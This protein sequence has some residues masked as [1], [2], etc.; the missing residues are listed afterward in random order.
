MH[1]CTLFIR[2]IAALPQLY[3]CTTSAYLIQ[4]HLHYVIITETAAPA[5]RHHRGDC[6]TCTTSSSRRLMHLHYV[7][8]AE[9]DAPALRHHRGDWCT[10]TSYHRGDWCT[11]QLHVFHPHMT[12]AARCTPEWHQHIQYR[13]TCTTP[14]ET[15][16]AS[17]LRQQRLLPRLHYIGIP[18]LLTGTQ[19]PRYGTGHLGLVSC[20]FFARISTA[21]Q[22]T[23]TLA[24]ALFQNIFWLAESP[25][26]ICIKTALSWTS[27]R[28]A[29]YY[30]Q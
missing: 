29:L 30:W 14:A 17:V 6:C 27:H 3:T 13:C 10:T 4:L 26:L 19:R 22:C 12:S 20:T 8:I 5:L 11:C 24:V 9:T 21:Y 15:A 23:Y 7:I 28:V 1:C 16:A 25:D 2:C 18:E